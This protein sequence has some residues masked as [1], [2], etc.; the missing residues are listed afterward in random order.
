MLVLYESSYNL[1]FAVCFNINSFQFG[2]LSFFF[3]S[4]LLLLFGGLSR[5]VCLLS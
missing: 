1:K 4:E 5:L 2:G 3:I